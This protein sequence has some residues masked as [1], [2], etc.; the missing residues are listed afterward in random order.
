[1]SAGLPE[2]KDFAIEDI[3][4]STLQ[5]LGRVSIECLNDRQ[6]GRRFSVE[7]Y[8]KKYPSL[9][10]ELLRQIL[11]PTVLLHEMGSASE[12]IAED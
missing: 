3:S 11:G 2:K 12:T 9:D 5:E 10:G 6:A 7:H 4:E 1:M 8:V